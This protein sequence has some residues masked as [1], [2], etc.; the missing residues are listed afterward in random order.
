MEEKHTHAYPVSVKKLP[1]SR[2]EIST[3]VTAEEFDATRSKAI[4][5]IGEDVE[6]PG[7]RKGHV[8]EKVL[9]AKIGESAI[10]EEMA[11]VAIGHAYPAI[12]VAEKLDVLGRPSVEIKKIA[13]GNPLE[14]TITT[15]VFP[16]FTTPD[17]KKLAAK[18]GDS[19]EVA[20]VSEDDI[21]KTIEQ[22]KRMRAQGEAQKEGREFDEATPLPELDDAYVATLG[23]FKT[24]A[25]FTEKLRENMLKEKER[26]IKDKKRVAIMEAI[27]KA[28]KIELPD[29]IVDQELA[30]MEDEFS[31]DVS[32]MGLD[33]DAYLKATGK[34]RDAMLAEWRPDAIKRATIQILVGRIAD[35]EKL[36]PD[37]ALIERDAAALA[38]RYPEADKERVHS[39]IHMLL[40]NEKVFEFLEAQA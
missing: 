25:E 36:E 26:E 10:L 37:Q 14:F 9:A 23:E 32:R 39:Y 3:T 8:P 15:A 16:E 6:L 13:M 21:N 35:E 28:T 33:M 18:A 38:A 24:V 20:V 40:T 22:I 4:A 29:V 19:K 11:E 5:R 12:V 34:T 2:I 30:R 7:F 27:V 1:G 17:Y 31:N